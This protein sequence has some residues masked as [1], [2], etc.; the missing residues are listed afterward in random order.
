MNIRAFLAGVA[1][2]TMAWTIPAAV[3]AADSAGAAAGSFSGKVLET[4]DASRYTYVMVDTGKDK[5][6][7]AAPTFKVKVGDSVGTTEGMLMRE[8]KSAALKRKFDEIYLC[9]SIRVQGSETGA[10][11]PGQVALPAGHPSLNAAPAL[12]AKAVDL[13]GIKAPE[14]GKTIA[15][16]WADRLAL[17][18]KTVTVR[19]KVVKA[20]PA[21]MGRNWLHLRDGTGS[22]GA[23]DLTVTLAELPAVGDTVTVTGVLETNVDFG[24]GYRYDVII[25]N[26]TRASK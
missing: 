25:Q 11:A 8:F 18:G 13:S 10:A 22:E 23:N 7:A 6:W 24:S 4:M 20:T 16:I 3:A 9:G 17:A 1:V 14:G 21:I 12:P 5:V 26:A 2:V 15:E 19:G